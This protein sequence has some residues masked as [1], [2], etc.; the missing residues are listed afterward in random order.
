[1]DSN[2]IAQLTEQSEGF[3]GAEIE[4]AI[5]AGLFEA[6]SEARGLLLRDLQRAI[7]NTVP[8]SITQAEQIQATREWAQLRAVAATSAEER[9]GYAAVPTPHKTHESPDIELQRGGRTVDF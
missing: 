5:V 3:S 2:V 8:L 7:Q 1:M 4:E 9:A 6:F